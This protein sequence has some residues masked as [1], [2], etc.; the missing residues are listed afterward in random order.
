MGAAVMRSTGYSP[1]GQYLYCI[2][3]VGSVRDIFRYD[4][5]TLAETNMTGSG[6]QYEYL[7]ISG[8]SRKLAYTLT[9]GT[10]SSIFSM[11]STPG[12]VGTLE[13]IGIEMCNM[14]LGIRPRTPYVFY[15]A[16][17]WGDLRKQV[18]TM[19][20]ERRAPAWMRDYIL[21]TDNPDDAIAFYQQVLQ[22][23]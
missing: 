12:G 5:T 16:G 6:K 17:F 1:D 21:F 14:K 22:I 20:N 9:D 18:E 4:T 2:K 10:D 15:N 11:P 7:A 13:E 3:G 23:A 8:D 19:I